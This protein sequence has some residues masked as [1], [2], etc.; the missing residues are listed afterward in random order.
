MSR[1][2][3]IKKFSKTYISPLAT[4]AAFIATAAIVPTVAAL[5]AAIGCLTIYTANIVSQRYLTKSSMPEK[6]KDITMQ[7][8]VSSLYIGLA[9][10]SGVTII[11]PIAGSAIQASSTLIGQRYEGRVE[12]I[13]EPD[14]EFSENTWDLVE[15]YK[16]TDKSGND[17]T[18]QT[19]TE[20]D[21]LDQKTSERPSE[22]L[23]TSIV[24]KSVDYACKFVDNIF[25]MSILIMFFM[26]MV[27]SVTSGMTK[28]MN[29]YSGQLRS[30]ELSLG[31]FDSSNFFENNTG[32]FDTC[33]VYRQSTFSLN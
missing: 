11:A 15:L 18:N 9:V 26:G 6:K 21:I 33:T 25:D 3:N 32:R 4:P 23:R 22:Q 13:K 2:S 31:E 12:K 30:S 24:V 10:F 8:I 27:V 19:K 20:K 1:I 14:H 7:A 29:D 28:I 17:S 5:P 16:E